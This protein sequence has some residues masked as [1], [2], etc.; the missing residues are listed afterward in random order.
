MPSASESQ[1]AVQDETAVSNFKQG[2]RAIWAAGD[3]PDVAERSIWDVGARIVR[4]TGIRRGED[5]LD[6]ACGSGNAA[7]RAAVAGGSVVGLDLTPELLDA[8]RRLAGDAGVWVEWIEG[9][10]EALPFLDETFDVVLSTFGCMFAPR[11]A[12]AASEIARVL[13]P[14]GRVSITAWTP[15]GSIGRFFETVVGYVPR[16]PDF[17]TPPV[18]WGSEQHVEEIF[19]DTGISLT[20]KRETVVMP[21]F[22]STDEALEYWTTKFGPVVIAKRFSEAQGTWPQLR[23][24]LIEHY[25]R[26]EPSEYLVILGQKD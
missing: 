8:A 2:A 3:F 15:E 19:A 16:P 18:L 1:T 12:V 14:G 26:N 17:A 11:H 22:D 13:R 10:A 24:E 25:A 4:H 23:A 9:D 21:P 20:F 5:V 7:I 6:V